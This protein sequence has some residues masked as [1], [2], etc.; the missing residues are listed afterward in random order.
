MACSIYPHENPWNRRR[1]YIRICLKFIR[2]YS[3]Q[4]SEEEKKKNNENVCAYQQMYVLL[5]MFVRWH[6]ICVYTGHHV[7]STCCVKELSSISCVCVLCRPNP[8]HLVDWFTRKIPFLTFH[9]R[10]LLH[11]LHTSDTQ[12]N[13]QACV[14]VPIT[15]N[16]MG[17]HIVVLGNANTE[18]ECCCARLHASTISSRSNMYATYAEAFYVFVINYAVHHLIYT[19]TNEQTN[20]FVNK[21]DRWIHFVRHSFSLPCSFS[22]KCFSIHP[23]NARRKRKWPTNIKT[24]ARCERWWWKIQYCVGMYCRLLYD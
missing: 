24:I 7:I 10:R 15:S 17:P 20:V 19:G 8:E 5:K 11:I 22:P 16:A 18:Y 2:N 13:E 23:A 4:K 3:N 12:W 1:T 14:C 9:T 21:Q 6:V